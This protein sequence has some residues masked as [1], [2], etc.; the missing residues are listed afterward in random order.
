MT[1]NVPRP[2]PALSPRDIR[3]ILLGL[4][5]AIFLGALEQTIVS[6]ALPHMAA[7]LQGTGLLAWVVSGY[8][9]ALAVSTPIYGKLGDL[10]GRRAVL[11][12]AICVFLLA[13]VW[14]ALATSM[15]MLIAARIVQGIGG[16]GLISVAQAT[17]ADVVAPRERGRY[18][19]YISGAYALASLAGPVLGGLLTKYLSWRW[20]F[21]INLP[22]GLA[23]L[24]ISRRA[25][26]RLAV[27]QVRHAIDTLG[28]VLL[29][30]SLSALLVGITRVGQGA[31]WLDAA[32]LQL[33]A[34]G[35]T[36][37][38]AFLWQEQRAAE[39]LIPLSLFR[40]RTVVVSCALL[41]I[42]F[43]ELVALTAL[44]PLRLQMSSGAGVD[45][46]AFEL[47]PLT[48]AGPCAALL[49][50]RMMVR[51][52]RY[53]PF[54]LAGAAIVAPAVLALALIDASATL[55]TLLCM[56]AAGLGMG[57]Q[58]PSS[59]VAVQNAVPSG[60]VGVA[61][62]VT[63]L[64]RALGAA[65]GIAILT[66]LLLATLRENTAAAWPQG[67]A[68]IL[69]DLLGQTLAA[70]A[71]GDKAALALVVDAAFRKIF[72]I[73]AGVALVAFALALSIPDATLHDER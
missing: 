41:F 33:F 24:L 4:T 48:L 55:P 61:T 43:F 53:R 11:S 51:T 66:A 5:L 29:S 9:L 18:Q 71:A 34:L 60:Q 62:A 8:L 16:G 37:L 39:P 17:I 63:A 26:A 65:M 54:Q 36:L 56:T 6:V 69:Q 46:A 47:L 22:L 20:I 59:M 21:W 25:M 2:M 7:A 64:F 68:I 50:G 15:P 3:S 13:S 52:G 35:A 40:N 31:Q 58:M 23:T 73:A 12:L 19:G 70:T 38:G 67:G 42:V 14:C 44:I 30:A 32:N 49:S 57:A 72:M 1:Q 28:A 27:P 10:Y 45:E